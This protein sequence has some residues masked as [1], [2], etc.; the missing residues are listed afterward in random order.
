MPPIP[1]SGETP[2]D[3]TM[4][5]NVSTTP[6]AGPPPPDDLGC[7]D[8]SPRGLW[9]QILADL[10]VCFARRHVRTSSLLGPRF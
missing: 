9:T 7:V 4:P 10:H 1:D 2:M 8:L 6:D 5:M 3:A